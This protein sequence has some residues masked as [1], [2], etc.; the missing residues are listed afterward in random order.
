MYNY[1]DLNHSK[2]CVAQLLPC[3]NARAAQVQEKVSNEKS[4]DNL[5]ITFQVFLFPLSF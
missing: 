1:D 3:S 5:Y 4:F 2:P